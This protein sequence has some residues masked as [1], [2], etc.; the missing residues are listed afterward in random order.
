MNDS[1]PLNLPALQQAELDAATLAHLF[2]DLGA[3]TQ[4]LAVVPRPTTRTQV[5][6]RS[7]TLDAAHAG[8]AARSFS[9]VQIRYRYDGR[10][11][12]DTL[13]PLPHGPVRLVRICTDEALAT[14]S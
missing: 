10:E 7:I 5:V 13:L 4:V 2:A 3:C 6:E 11:W 1:S 12:A 14:A 9:G 8:L